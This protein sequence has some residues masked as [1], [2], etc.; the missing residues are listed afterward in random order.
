[1]SPRNCASCARDLLIFEDQ[2]SGIQMYSEVA[3]L[4]V[5]GEHKL[6]EGRNG[7]G[8]NSPLFQAIEGTWALDER[9]GKY[10]PRCSRDSLT[11]LSGV[12]EQFSSFPFSHLALAMCARRVGDVGWRQYADRAMEILKHTTQIAGSH[13]HHAESYRLLQRYLTEDHPRGG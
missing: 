4:N 1:M 7:I 13:P 6:A 12:T 8:W 11:R 5:L 3:E 10:R 9:D 2:I